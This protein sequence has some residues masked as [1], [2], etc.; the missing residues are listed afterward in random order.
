MGNQKLPMPLMQPTA[1]IRRH[2]IDKKWIIV[3]GVLI[4]IIVVVVLGRFLSAG[5]LTIDSN[6]SGAQ[7]TINQKK[8]TTPANVKLATGVYTVAI[9]KKGY[10]DD[11]QKI[12]IKSHQKTAITFNL[13]ANDQIEPSK[14]QTLEALTQ[15]PFENDH[16]RILWHD[17]NNT[18]EIVPKIPFA[19]TEPPESY[20]QNYWDQY[21]QFGKEGIQW[22]EKNQ[23]GNDILNRYQITIVWWGKEWWPE[24]KTAPSL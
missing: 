22:L 3:G 1:A 6:P 4:A 11:S 15:L 10:I 13:V 14:A 23:L 21:E 20:F 5:E 24:G 7:V 18:I 8:V 2:M 17:N 9:S 19:S 16:F 12:T